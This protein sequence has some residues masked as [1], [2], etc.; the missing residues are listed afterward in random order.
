M[1]MD[2]IEL[3]MD[4]EDVLALIIR[5]TVDPHSTTFVTPDDFTQQAGFVVYPAGGHIPAHDH[6]PIQRAL[7]GTAE[8]LVVRRG[9][10]EARIYDRRRRL[11]ATRVLATGDVLMLVNGGHGFTMIE[12]TV[13]F[14]IKQGP[15]T[16][17]V[18]KERFE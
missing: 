13:L 16:G 5:A 6:L 15:Y 8:T 1:T 18:E 4:G 3:L 7:I 9:R 10:M 12:D 11:N 2:G 17:L 14:E